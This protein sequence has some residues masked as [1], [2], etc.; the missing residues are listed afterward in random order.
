M[1]EELEGSLDARGLRV[2]IIVS[3]FNEAVTSR[4]LS[5]AREALRRNGVAEGAITVVHVPGSLELPQAA[6]R[7]AASGR[8]DALVT[9]GCVV[10]GETAHFDL[11]VGE[12]ARGVAEVAR[13][14]G[15]PVSFGVL[16]TNTMQQALD[17]SGGALGNRGYDSA[18]AALKMA[19]LLPRLDAEAGTGE[20]A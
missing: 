17:R 8:W 4:L 11:V 20:G 14:S 15:V 10:R 6:A 9:L 7:M 3:Q 19:S 12:S 2:G 18:E 1:A 5:G 16:T 13:T